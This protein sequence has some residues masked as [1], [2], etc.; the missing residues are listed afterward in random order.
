[1]QGKRTDCGEPIA[2]P[3]LEIC[4]PEPTLSWAPIALEAE[5]LAALDAPKRGHE[6][7][8][9]AL[10]R[11][12]HEIGAVLSR[13]TPADSLVLERRVT[14]SLPGDPIAA[15]FARLLP[16]RRQRLLNFAASIRRRPSRAADAGSRSG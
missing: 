11:K 16:D 3:A 7:F 4:E 12:E 1:M 10:R 14:L 8:D 13:L 6:T 9:A 15:R 5:M 2:A